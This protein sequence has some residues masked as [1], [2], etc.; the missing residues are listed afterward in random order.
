MFIANNNCFAQKESLHESLKKDSV[1][2]AKIKKKE[3]IV[4]VY[5]G[6]DGPYIIN[7]TLFQ[8]DSQNRLVIIPKFN[9]DSI[10]VRV[11]NK[12]N[13]EFSI[14]LERKYRIPKTNYSLPKKMIVISDIEGNY[15]AFSGFLYANKVIDDN[16]NW[17]FGDG[18][19]VLVGDF[20][21]RGKNVTQV[22]WLIYKL[23][24]QA[25]KQKG[26][27]HFIL[28]NHEIMNFN[29]DYRYN[30]KKY[31]KAA[32]EISK[33]QNKKE[34]L[35]YLYSVNSELGKWLKTKNIIE[36]IGNYIFVHA[37][38]HPTILNYKLSLRK[39]NNIARSEFRSKK[40]SK[41]STTKFLFGSKGP[42]W[43]R[44][45][46]FKTRNYKKITL[47]ELDTILNYYN[48]KKIVIGH[49]HVKKL[50]TDF[51]GKV[52]RTDVIHGKEKFSSKTQG[53]LVENNKE[54]IINAN[55]TKKPLK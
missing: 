6:N 45:L 37:G 11:D 25:K 14:S 2:K 32:Q 42:F 12:D 48:A 36:K 20:F 18:H 1:Y 54:F 44:G 53:L 7:D 3:K 17:M 10:I 34:A 8:V 40:K 33:I 43:Y 38:L 27:V 9:K 28:G 24:Q 55:F 46:F 16:H 35:K 41:N 19:L 51:N 31:I 50:S 49:T 21:D 26:M 29:G 52:I 5:S 13:D 22:L 47:T 15:D 4:P 23:E 30:R 39:I